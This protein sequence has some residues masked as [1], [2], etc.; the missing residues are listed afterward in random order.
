M[1]ATSDQD[2]ATRWP[3]T[4]ADEAQTVALACRVGEWLKPGDLVT[5]SGDLGAG[6][7]TFARALIRRMTGAPALDVAAAGDDA[8][9]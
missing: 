7:T 9:R 2:P 3:L 6:K 8:A 5:L 1:E 4:L